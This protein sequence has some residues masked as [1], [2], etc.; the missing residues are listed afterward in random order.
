MRLQPPEHQRK[1]F[2]ENLRGSILRGYPIDNAPKIFRADSEMVRKIHEVNWKNIMLSTNNILAELNCINMVNKDHVYT[3][4][5]C[6]ALQ[7]E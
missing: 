2:A 3:F 4:K 1:L 6:P 7:K 5:S